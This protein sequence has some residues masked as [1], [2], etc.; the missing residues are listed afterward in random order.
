M[1]FFKKKR[2]K[3]TLEESSELP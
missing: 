3:S 2:K 1:P